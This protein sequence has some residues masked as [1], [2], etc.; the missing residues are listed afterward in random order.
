MCV[1]YYWMRA[2]EFENEVL[3][4]RRRNTG[5]ADIE[6]GHDNMNVSG[7]ALFICLCFF[8]AFFGD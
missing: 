3:T 8:W 4:P 2:K 1:V 7:P 5:K 6:F